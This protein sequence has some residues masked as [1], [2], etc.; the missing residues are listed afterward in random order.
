MSYTYTPDFATQRDRVR[1]EIGDTAFTQTGVL[2]LADSEIA[3][4]GTA[5]GNDFG[6]AARCCEFLEAKFAQKADMTEGKLSIRYS[7]RAD[8][9]RDKAKALRALGA[10]TGA[11][12]SAGGISIADKTAADQ[13]TDRVPPAFW[14]NML[15]NPEAQPLTPGSENVADP[16]DQTN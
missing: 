4:A 7:Q 5:E 6:T 3:Y 1:L 9:Y 11:L 12:P 13:D 8:S 15:D 16:F 14:R 10:M 2:M